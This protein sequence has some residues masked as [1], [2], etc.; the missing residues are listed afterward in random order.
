MA[1]SPEGGDLKKPKG[2]EKYQNQK[3]VIGVICVKTKK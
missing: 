2:G 3:G 1:E